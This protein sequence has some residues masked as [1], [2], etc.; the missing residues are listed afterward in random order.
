M[1]E[2]AVKGRDPWDDLQ[3]VLD[4]ELNRLPD[5]YRCAIVLC[6]LEGETRQEVARQFRVPEGTLS[7]WLTRG[8]AL[9]AKRLARHGLAVSGSSLAVVLAQGTASACVPP[10]VMSST[11]NA[12]SVFAAGQ[13]A[14]AGVISLEVAALTEGVLK[15]MFLTKLKI[16]TAVVGVIAVLSVGVASLTQRVLAQK[17]ASADPPAQTKPKEDG[18]K[19]K[20]VLLEGHRVKA[21]DASK[22]TITIGPS[23]EDLKRAGLRPGGLPDQTFDVAQNASIDIDGKPGKLADLPLRALI[24]LSVSADRKTVQSIQTA[25]LGI[26]GFAMVKAVNAGKS[27]ITVDIKARGI[28]LR[29]D[30]QTYPVAKHATIEI[31]GKPGKLA[32]LPIGAHVTLSLS[33]NGKTALG[34]QAGGPRGVV[35]AVDARANTLTMTDKI[36][37]AT[38]PVVQGARI[39]LDG[40]PAKLADLKEDMEVDLRLTADAET[41]LKITAEPQLRPAVVKAVDAG[42]NTLTVTDKFGQLTFMVAQGA[43]IVI[44]GKAGTLADL[45]EGMEVGLRLSADGKTVVKLTAGGK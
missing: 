40:K 6:D 31:D 36:G 27:A 39:V 21:V 28:A 37:E 44:D 9:L 7:G 19:G 43:K 11:I 3:T 34:I 4:Q 29:F 38:F 20:T 16:A 24:Q 10:S 12:A 33:W 13:K 1:P 35:K 41:V 25:R 26:N 22:R 2:A 32:D 30:G 5:R 45:K 15:T 42:A 18:K 23:L 14:S 17:P 8:R